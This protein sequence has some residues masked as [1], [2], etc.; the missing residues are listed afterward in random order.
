MRSIPG[1]IQKALVILMIGFSLTAATV[2]FA[3]RGIDAG[4]KSELD[5]TCNEIQTK[6]SARLSAYAL[7]LRSGSSLF[8]SSDRVTREMWKSFNEN[9]KINK[10]LP[11]V[12]GVGFAL[13]IPENEL[14]KHIQDTKDEGFP[15]YEIK[16]AGDRDTYTSIIYIE[17]FAG[18]NL[19]AFGYDMFTES[20]RRKAMEMARDSDSATLSGKVV[21]VQ[22]TGQDEQAGCLMYVPVYRNGMPSNT[23]EQR[24]AAIMGW[25][26]SPYRMNDLMHG[27][28]GPWGLLVDQRIHL[29]IYDGDVVAENGLLFDS[30]AGNTLNH[31]DFSLTSLSLPLEFNGQAWTLHFSKSRGQFPY[32]NSWIIFIL[33]CGMAI[34][35]LLFALYLALSATKERMLIAERLTLEL[36]EREGEF[37]FLSNQLQSI[38]DHIP[39]LIF[40]KDTNNNFIRVNKYMAHGL[41]KT[42]EELEGKNLVEI[43]PVEDAGKYYQD[44]LQVIHSGVAKLDIEEKWEGPDGPQ[45]VSSSKIPFVDSSGRIIGVIGISIDITGR[46]KAEALMV[47][48]M[49]DAETANRAKSIFLANMSHEIRTPLNAIIGFSQLMIRDKLLSDKQKE[50]SHFIVNSGEHLLSLIND[51]LDLS[52][53]EAGRVALN[54]TDID[55]PA[56]LRDLHAI[57]RER[58]KHTHLRFLFETTGDLPR[59][60]TGDESKLRRIFVNLIENALKFTDEGGV[61]V[62]VRA[63]Q[64]DDGEFLLVVEIQDSGPGISQEEQSDL[65]E[66]FVQTSTGIKKGTGTGLGLALSHELATLMGG[67]ITCSS[68]VGAGSVF[69]FH[70]KMRAGQ[71][72]GVKTPVMK[73]V[74]GIR[75]REGTCRVLVVDDK[76]ENMRV[77]VNLLNIVGFETNEAINGE[78]AV[79]RFNEWSPDLVLM[80]LRM[81]VM[82]GYEAARQIKSTEKGQQTPI[83]ALTASAFEET[84]LMTTPSDLQGFIRK[85]FRENEL[86]GTIGR[87]LGMDY[88]Y[89]DETPPRPAEYDMNNDSVRLDIAK[90]PVSLVSRISQALA[91]ADLNQMIKLIQS[92]EPDHPELAQYL[93]A[94]ATNYEYDYLMRLLIGKE[95][96]NA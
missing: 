83:I 12:Q 20:I 70:V 73:R 11:G 16:P 74:T 37:V 5:V 6:I 81:P 48:A 30:D 17:P 33:I 71:P 90:L 62:R 18:M 47:S 10:N 79:A 29:Q 65:F 64:A 22:E 43:Y 50:Y 19:R 13:I 85:P 42:R 31:D 1:N 25:V 84:K 3:K 86:F 77:V 93:M 68:E 40:Y 60:V 4:M 69:T 56:F 75:K 45:W 51:I 7:L 55:L 72:G 23:V 15:N 66:Y 54:L 39:G 58:A 95:K 52:K 46:K 82:D 28:M 35:F 2:F 14:Q 38:L 94:L 49:R 24:R 92:I 89:E 36:T 57:Y 61:A 67:D 80:D 44:D 8:A 21:L 53:I 59:Y 78:E 41:G 88:I 34:S 76:E 87:I 9:E 27:I 32:F 91:V 26:Y 63:D 96:D